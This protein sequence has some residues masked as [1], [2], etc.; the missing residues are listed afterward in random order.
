[1]AQTPLEILVARVGRLSGGG[2][3]VDVVGQADRRDIDPELRRSPENVQQHPPG[4]PSAPSCG[5][6]VE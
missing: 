2:D 1:M 4:A 5:Q 3:R 6:V